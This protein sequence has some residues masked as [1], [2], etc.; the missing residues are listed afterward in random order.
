M[1]LFWGKTGTNERNRGRLCAEMLVNCC[2]DWGSW[3]I[4]P[5]NRGM[6]VAM[7]GQKSVIREPE[8]GEAECGDRFPEIKFARTARPAELPGLRIETLRQAQVK[9]SGT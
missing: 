8:D 4:R 2:A 5:Q 9:L 1:H 6:G 7:R 3:L